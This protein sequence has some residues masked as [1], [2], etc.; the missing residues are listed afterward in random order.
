MYKAAQSAVNEGEEEAAFMS[1]AF[2][3]PGCR[4]AGGG[5]SGGD[6]EGA[7]VSGSDCADDADIW[8]WMLATSLALPLPALTAPVVVLGAGWSVGAAVASVR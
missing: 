3:A 6:D 8:R 7:A 4:G 5:V 1:V 2:A